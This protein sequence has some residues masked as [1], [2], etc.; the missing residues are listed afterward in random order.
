M[1]YNVLSCHLNHFNLYGEK[2]VRLLHFI[3]I[4][5]RYRMTFAQV[6]EVVSA[7]KYYLGHND[8]KRPF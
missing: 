2:E 5:L 4:R 1:S 6:A 3:D 7:K 8:S